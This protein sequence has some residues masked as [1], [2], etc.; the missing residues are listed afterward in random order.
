MIQRLPGK[1]R[2]ERTTAKWQYGWTEDLNRLFTKEDGQIIMGKDAQSHASKWKLK[3]RRGAHH[4]HQ[5]GY[6]HKVTNQSNTG[7]TKCL[8]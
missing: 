7:H 2:K 8:F 3:A 6:S 5:N 4:S 1:E